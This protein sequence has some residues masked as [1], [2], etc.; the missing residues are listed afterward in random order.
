MSLCRILIVRYS[1]FSPSTRRFSFFTTVPAPWCGYTTLS[2]TL[3]KPSSPTSR[4]Y[5]PTNAGG[6]VPPAQVLTSVA[7][8]PQMSH[9]LEKPCSLRA[10]SGVNRSTS[11]IRALSELQIAVDQIVL[12]EPAEPLADVAGPGRAHPLHRLEVALG[13]TDDRVEAVH[14]ADHAVDDAGRQA[15]DVREDAVSAGRHRVVEG[16]RRARIAQQLLDPLELEE[17]LVAEGGEALARENGLGARAGDVEVVDHRGLLGGDV[18]EELGQTHADHAS[19]RTELD[20]VAL[21]LL[22]H[23]GRQL[24][25]LEHD[26]HVV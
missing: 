25:A 11:G 14:V 23:P 3:N 18:P 17:L 5:T 7:K 16:V 24:G 13:R 1:R 6:C 4:V 8:G 21:D 22:G 15:R 9:F 26:E 12:L 2:P 10:T 20:A 19:L